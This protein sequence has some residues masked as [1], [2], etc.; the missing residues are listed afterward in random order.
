MCSKKS[1]NAKHTCA[2]GINAYGRRRVVGTVEKIC[3]AIQIFALVFGVFAMVRR[4]CD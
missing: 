1:C 2:R 4:S 3:L